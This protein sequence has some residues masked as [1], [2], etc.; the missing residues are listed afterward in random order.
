M[1][2]HVDAFRPIHNL[3]SMA[4]LCAALAGGRYDARDPKTWLA[5]AA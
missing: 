3:A 5:D 2:P 1:L 4:D